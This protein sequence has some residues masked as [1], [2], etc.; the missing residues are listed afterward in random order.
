VLVAQPDDYSAAQLRHLAAA[1]GRLVLVAP[2]TRAAAAVDP[3]IQ[4]DPQVGPRPAP[5]CPD[6]GAKA[7]G[8]VDF[9]LDTVTYLAGHSG[10]VSC[11]AGALLTEPR[12]AVLGSAE[13]LQNRRLADR[14]VAALDVNAITDSRRF[15]AVVWLLPGADAAGP[16]PASVWDLFPPAAHRAFWW[17][18]A[19][20]VLLVLWRARRLGG[21][22]AEPLP[23]VVRA[24]EIVEGHGRLY[25]RAGAR[26]RAS[27]ALRRATVGR[28]AHRLGLPRGASAEQVAVAAAGPAGSAPVHDLLAGPPPRDDAALLRLAHDLDEL[29][30][31]TPEGERH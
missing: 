3:S 28:L 6:P 1:A 17:L 4:P 18:I 20:G 29:E 13:L 16:G 21:V 23:V 31:R 5:G 22:V 8:P 15:G 30:A 9:P 11:Y 14:G 27:A 7:T 2:G 26:E 12:L 10:A 25:A 24:A 19:V